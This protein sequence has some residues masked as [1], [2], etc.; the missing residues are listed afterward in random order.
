MLGVA[1]VGVA[2]LGVAVLL[3]HAWWWGPLIHVAKTR[4]A[5]AV[6]TVVGTPPQ[7]LM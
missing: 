6:G 2:M 4:T 1:G 5:T 7:W 3:W